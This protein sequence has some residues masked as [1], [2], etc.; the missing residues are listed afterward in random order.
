MNQLPAASINAPATAP[1]SGSASAWRIWAWAFA[2]AAI[3]CASHVMISRQRGFWCDEYLSIA[4]FH[5]PLRNVMLERLHAGHSPLYFLLAR[6][7]LLFGDAEWQLRAPTALAYGALLLCLTGLFLSV[8]L[9][10]YLPGLW[11]V[12]LL[13]PYWITLTTQ[14]RYMMPLLAAEALTIWMFVRLVNR[15]TFWRGLWLA[16]CMGLAGWINIAAHLINIPLL[17]FAL[18]RTKPRWKCVVPIIIGILFSMPLI[19]FTR[20]H[21]EEA[22][23]AWP[24]VSE[25]GRALLETV[26]GS[27]RMW[28]EFFHWRNTPFSLLHIAVLAASV[29]L[30]RRELLR[31][32][33]RPIWRLLA[34]L[35]VGIPVIFVIFCVAVRSFSSIGRY[36]AGFGVPVALC[37]GVAWHAK[38]KPVALWIY[39]IA[40]LLVLAVQSLATTIDHYDYHKQAID[41]LMQQ[42]TGIEPI[43]GSAGVVTHYALDAR[44]FAHTDQFI[45][46]ATSEGSRS[47]VAERM[48]PALRQAQRGFFIVYFSNAPVFDAIRRMQMQGIIKGERHWQLSGKTLVGAMIADESQRQWLES[49]PAPILPWGPVRYKD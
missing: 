12:I 45:A 4:T 34:C 44:R 23:R 33:R 21:S 29:Y 40:L 26:F 42:H 43:I 7:G 9:R 20:H 46:I 13:Q 16:L 6:V 24:D 1:S 19:Y 38:T 31:Q 28:P 36:V 48:L 18:W 10:R 47:A 15:P 25:F 14:V 2:I 39:R 49:L 27:Y 5:W 22:G 41:W 30:A 3:A 17:I 37:M 35:L 8:G 32:R 11:A